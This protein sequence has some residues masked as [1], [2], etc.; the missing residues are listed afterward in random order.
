MV[1]LEKIMSIY[2]GSNKLP[3]KDEDRQTHYPI[4][5]ETNTFVGENNTTKVRF[6]V[7]RIGGS[8][9][10]WVAKVK[11]PNGTICFRVLE[12]DNDD[13]V[14]VDLSFLYTD[15]VGQIDLA[16][17]GYTAQDITITEDDGV[18]EISGNPTVICTGIVKIIINYSPLLLN[19]GASVQPSEY[20]QMLAMLSQLDN[21]LDSKV[22]KITSGTKIY[23]TLDGT[24]TSIDYGISATGY[25]IVQR[26]SEGQVKVPTTP[27][28]S[29]DAT[30]K[31]YVDDL[32]STKQELLI[33]EET[34]QLR[35]GSI[36]N[37]S[38]QNAVG[39]NK[40]QE[41]EGGKHHA[42]ILNTIDDAYYYYWVLCLYTEDKI[43][44]YTEGAEFIEKF[45]PYAQTS[46]RFID[47]DFDE[48]MG[49]YPTARGYAV[50]MFAYNW[51]KSPIQKRVESVGNCLQ[52]LYNKQIVDFTN[53]KSTIFSRNEDVKDNVF[54]SAK[55]GIYSGGEFDNRNKLF[56]MVVITDTHGSMTQFINAITY[57]QDMPSIDAGVHLGDY[58]GSNFSDDD[59]TWLTRILNIT[60][61]PFYIACGNHD[62][63]QST[64][65]SVAGTNA[66]YVAKFITPNLS[67]L[68]VNTDK[69]YY[70]VKDTQHGIYFIVLNNFDSPDTIVDGQFVVKKG[71]ECLSQAQIDWFI[72]ELSE[73]PND[74]NLVIMQ[75]SFNWENTEL[76]CNFSQPNINLNDSAG[77][78]CYASSDN[79]IPRIVDAWKN[80][81]SVS[82]TSEALNENVEDLVISA[83]FSSR[84]N[85]NFVCYL[86]GH[87][88]KDCVAYSTPFPD[89]LIIGFTTGS[90]D[91]S[92]NGTSDLPRR[93][94]DKTQD[95]FT[96]FSFDPNKKLVNLVRVGSNITTYMVNRTMIS[97]DYSTYIPKD[98]VFPTK[99][100]FNGKLESKKTYTFES[101]LTSLTISQFETS[102][103]DENPMWQLKFVVGSGF[104]ISV[105]ENATWVGG[106]PTFTQNKQYILL[107]DKGTNDTYN[108]HIIED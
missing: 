98:V 31:H 42:R 84:T 74:Y 94:Y 33:Y 14:D 39:F 15:Q 38:N 54:A 96:I 41:I 48:L 32:S 9:Y 100:T 25:S 7:D 26:N 19:I 22:D 47:I 89:Q 61:K 73:V 79:I 60:D 18:Y 35:N 20:Q 78:D 44:E 23:A 6:Y 85:S 8:N 70:A 51:D 66:Q 13:Y 103:N 5:G 28:E 40:V 75:H 34:P 1:Q 11:K 93:N 24:Q 99:T 37:P 76:K 4:A 71:A 95:A 105:P 43:G 101:A 45:E 82:F 83:D 108:L 69:P 55:Y 77:D 92:N 63:G 27:N 87:T 12:M 36:T 21:D 3:Y 49:K 29:D 16:L 56:S 107:V 17:N 59:G 57:C 81:T 86:V 10:T 80:K 90:M 65:P 64:N 50:C 102:Q 58:Q 2:Y 62:I 46:N 88:H 104:S 68:R 97:I 91:A 106:T 72:N 53:G 30:S 52:I 67:H